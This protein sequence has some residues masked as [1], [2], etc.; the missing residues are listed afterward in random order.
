M[1]LLRC[2]LPR[3]RALNHPAV[4]PDAASKG[5]ELT[6]GREA[7]DLRRQ[8]APPACSPPLVVG[9]GPPQAGAFPHLASH[10]GSLGVQ[11]PNCRD[12]VL[13]SHTRR[14][15]GHSPCRS[16]VSSGRGSW[17]KAAWV[18]G[19]ESSGSSSSSQGMKRGARGI[20]CGAAQAPGGAPSPICRP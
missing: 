18:W 4:P 20:L 11:L 2:G 7:T 1:H 15:T 14:R 5:S 17:G 10:T 9:S 6:Q 8:R 16:E 3:A 13:S 12:R 19:G